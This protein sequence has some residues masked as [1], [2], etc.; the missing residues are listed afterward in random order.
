MTN[1]LWTIDTVREQ[2]P[3]VPVIFATGGDNPHYTAPK[4]FRLAGRQNGFG[5]LM[6]PDSLAIITASWDAI[7]HVLN[8]QTAIRA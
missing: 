4:N 5:T 6:D 3:D 7:V 2:L 8:N 1:A